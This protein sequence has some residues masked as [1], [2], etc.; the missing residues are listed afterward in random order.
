MDFSEL[1]YQREVRDSLDKMLA[2]Q[3]TPENLK[4]FDGDNGRAKPSKK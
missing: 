2:Q 3:C 1:S 4:K